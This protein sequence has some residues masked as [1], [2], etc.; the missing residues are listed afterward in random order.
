MRTSLAALLGGLLA[1]AGLGAGPVRADTIHSIT[2]YSYDALNR[3]ICTAVRMDVAA[4]LPADACAVTT[5]AGTYGPDRV[6]KNVYDDAG[7]LTQVIQALGV[8][9]A[10][11][12][13]SDVQ[14]TYAT[15]SYTDNGK[16]K[17]I[18]DA[19]GNLTE[20]TYD[21]LDRLVQQNFPSTTRGAGTANSADYEAYGYDANGNRTKLRKRDGL[22]LRFC[23]DALNRETIRRPRDESNCAAAGEATDV[24]RTYDLQGRLTSARFQS[25][26]GDGVAYA[27]D[28]LGRKLSETSYGRAV[29]YCYG[30][31]ACSSADKV[32][33]TRVGWPDSASAG[34]IA[35][36][37]DATGRLTSAGAG[38][39]VAA[40]AYDGLGRLTSIKRHGEAS[41]SSGFGYDAVGRLTSLTLDLSDTYGDQAETLAY[42]P[43]GQMFKDTLSNAA[44]RWAGLNTSLTATA[45]GLNRDSVIAAL[46]GYDGNQNL[47]KDGD[48]VF[49]YD[50]ENRLKT[51]SG[52]ATATLDYDPL[53]RLRQTTIN[54]T[55]TQYLYDGDQL[56]A[57]YDGSGTALRRYLHGIGTDDPLVWFEGAGLGDARYLHADRQGSIIGWSNASGV[58]QAIYSYGPYG[59]PGDRWAPGSRFRYTGQAALPELKL[60][61]YKARVYDPARGWFLQTD[62]IGYKDDNNLYAYTGQDP[63]NRSDPTG[64]QVAT[65][66][67]AGAA[68]GCLVTAEVGCGG[69]AGAI[70]GGGIGAGISFCAMSEACR[71]AVA[72]GLA[73]GMRGVIILPCALNGACAVSVIENLIHRNEQGGRPSDGLPVQDGATVER[74]GKGATD[75]VSG[76]PGGFTE[77]N[78]DFDA[79][80]DPDTVKDRGNG[81]RTG[82]TADGANITVRPTSNDGRATVEV[83]RG[84]GRNRNT[85][86]F[87]YG[88]GE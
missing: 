69:G 44:Y 20:L 11:G 55:T 58:S 38:G 56:I 73:T 27:Y 16:Q 35:Y 57:E 9:V 67:R 13:P 39:A 87:R 23:Y 12:F 37:Y 53:G 2:Q 83:T 70:V 30:G 54:G 14:R 22:T 66:A 85:D 81:I 84:N 78:E 42:N 51:V 29:T 86:K 50:A 43:A 76:K 75:Q 71:S 17:T 25:T 72:N 48:R 59:E 64:T 28:A 26:A 24:Y 62:P 47:T 18:T 65:A 40:F 68:V 46:N 19:N 52:P 3:P 74:P 32:N 61:H 77:A 34:Y 33:P 80:V 10:A 49:T 63:L 88:Q 7:Q 31:A 21:G 79:S 8:T 1:V 15:Y 60:Y 45:D 6:T 4:S 5:P 36:A 41:P 82:Q